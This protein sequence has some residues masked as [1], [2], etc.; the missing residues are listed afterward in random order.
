MRIWSE[1]HKRFKKR[2]MYI[3]LRLPSLASIATEKENMKDFKM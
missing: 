3:K 2:K 1:G